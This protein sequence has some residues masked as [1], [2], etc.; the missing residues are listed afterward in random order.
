M[1]NFL[2]RKKTSGSPKRK[3]EILLKEVYR[4][5]DGRPWYEYS[6]PLT[7]PAKRAIAAEIATRYA[8]LNLS[9]K[10][11]LLIIEEMKKKA[12]DGNIVEVFNL[13]SEIEY[14]T[15]FLA[16]E[17]TLTEL[18]LVYFVAGDEEDETTYSDI[19]RNR[20]IEIFKRDPEAKDFFLSAAWRYT[21]RFSDT[22]DVDIL[23]YLR[24]NLRDV[25]RL[26]L[27][28]PRSR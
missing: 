26:S 7:L 2:K 12:N 20:K 27:L 1:L 21:I 18:A 17:E 23:A 22:S 28:T 19:D 6:N 14:R 3:R 25:E 24:T 10:N 4:D 16:E 8:D 9:K 11:L 13:L 5:K 15:N